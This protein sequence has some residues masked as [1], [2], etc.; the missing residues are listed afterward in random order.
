MSSKHYTD[1]VFKNKKR[2]KNPIKFKVQLNQEQKRVKSSIIDNPITVV[3]GKA[4]SGKTLIATQVGLDMLFT[5]Q[6]EKVVIT[7]PTVSKEEIGFLPGD[8]REKMDPW[9]TPIYHNL[10]MLYSKEKVDKEIEQENIEIVPFAFMRGR[11]Q[12]L[13]SKVLTPKGWS[14][15][16]DIKPGSKVIGKDGKTHNVTAI[17]PQ[18]KELVYRVT[19]SD[20]SSTLVSGKHLW[21][22]LDTNK[23]RCKP[24]VLTT[25]DLLEQGLHQK[26]TNKKK[27]KIPVV[28]PVQFPKKELSIDPYLLGAL[29]GDG[30]MTDQISFSSS[31]NFIVEQIG[32]LLPEG[33]DIKKRSGDNYDYGISK[34]KRNNHKENALKI[35][36]Y[37]LGLIGKTSVDKFIPDQ[38][39]YAS[40]E[41]R[42][43]LLQGLMDT[44]GSIFSGGKHTKRQTSSVAHFYTISPSLRDSVIFLVQ[45]LGGTVRVRQNKV[46]GTVDKYGF[47]Y[48]HNSYDLS[49]R[50]PQEINPFRLPR[51]AN[52]FEVREKPTRN[53]KSIEVE[54][55]TFTQCISVDAPDNLYITDE[56]IVTHNTFVDSFVIVD[57]AQNVTQNQMETVIG[58]LGI[59]SKMVICGDMAQIDLKSRKD[60]G[61]S[62]LNRVEENVEGLKVETLEKNHRHS[63]VE[64]ILEV[65][66]TF[67]D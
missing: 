3:R 36:L 35:D 6:V 49:I 62:F 44:D 47:W 57:E 38:Y 46:G 5:K 53:I 40:V 12:P 42:I 39:L 7:R 55:E 2:P 64:P 37:N 59:N 10:Y 19:F 14:V 52:L 22:V 43:A 61:F 21:Q 13:D 25:E 66:Q 58:R 17:F 33:L 41:Q 8:V 50:L 32:K 4:G 11:A 28:E 16:G 54:R 63:I 26:G 9:L 48:N 29:L 45:S 56:C 65:Y 1:E 67:R 24:Q 31:D 15:I 51:K 20:D 18:G 34:I 27:W 60:T 30:C 23:L